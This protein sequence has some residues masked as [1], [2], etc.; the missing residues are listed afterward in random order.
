MGNEQV[1][2]SFLQVEDLTMNF[3]SLTAVDDVDISVREREIHAIIGPNGAGKTTLFNMISGT[4]QPT[5]GR[6]FF[7]GNDVTNDR[8]YQRARRGISRAFQITHLFTDMSIAENLQI[9]AMPKTSVHNPLEK[10]DQSTVERAAQMFEELSIGATQTTLT[11]NLSHG[12]KKKLEIGM[13]LLTD[14]DL[15]LLDE[16]TSGVSEDDSQ[17]LITY[18]E[19]TTE[20]LTVVLIEHDVDIILQL[21]DRI[22][23]LHQ[24]AVIAEGA[25]AEITENETVQRV[26]LG[27]SA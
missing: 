5:E 9:A 17:Q 18:I 3:G 8:T 20:D 1:S 27:G 13:T 15:L 7:R 24:G 10:V 22:T 21:A 26:Y 23:V 6:I 16:P 2:E 19:R 4:L 11:K 14:P 12:D 25:P